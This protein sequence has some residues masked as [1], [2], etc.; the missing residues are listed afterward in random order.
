MKRKSIQLIVAGGIDTKTNPK[1]VKPGS[2]LQMDN[3]YQL[4]TG[5]WRARNGF[6]GIL[7]ADGT[8]GTGQAIFAGATGG[9]QAIGS[10]LVEAG[11]PPGTWN[12]P[13][14]AIARYS[15]SSSSWWPQQLGTNPAAYPLYTAAITEAKGQDSSTVMDAV[16]PD[17]ALGSATLGNVR[18]G[19]FALSNFTRNHV[20]ATSLDARPTVGMYQDN[21]GTLTRQCIK[22]VADLST[23]V[24]VVF[25]NGANTLSMV[26]YVNGAWTGSVVTL[27]TDLAANGF[28]DI[29]QIPGSSNFV[30]AYAVNG[31]GIKCGIF[32]RGT[33]GPGLSGTVFTA[34]GDATLCLGFLDDNLATGNMYLATAGTTS[35]VVLRTMSAVTLAVSATVA[36]DATSTAGV[37]NVTGHVLTGA[38]DLVV[39]WDKVNSGSPL[40]DY[41]MAAHV[42]GGTPTIGHFYGNYSLYSRT[43]LFPDGRY[44][45]LG[46]LTSTAQP[47]YVLLAT[48]TTMQQ[49]SGFVAAGPFTGCPMATV[50]TG[51]GGGRRLASSLASAVTVGST[52]TIPAARKRSIVVPGGS[53][54]QGR[55]MAYLTFSAMTGIN[56]AKELGGSVFLPGGTPIVDDGLWVMPGT[57]PLYPEIISATG[58]GG[59]GMTAS[60]SYNYRAVLKIRDSTGRVYRSAGS[61]PFTGTT[62]VGQGTIAVV[63]PNYSA[64]RGEGPL[65]SLELYRQGPA[66]SGANLYN[67]VLESALNG[68]GATLTLTDTMSDANAALGEVAYFTGNVLEHFQPPASSVLEVN[69]QRVG[70]INAEAPTEFWFSK[71]L[72]PGVGLGFNPQ[73]KI[74]I[75]GDGAGPL[76]AISAMDGRWILFKASAIYVVSGVGPDDTGAGTFNQPQAITRTVGTVNPASVIETPEGIL[77]QASTG[78]GNQGGIWLVGRDLSVTYV[79]APVEAYALAGNVVGAALCSILPTVRLVFA[80]GRMIE[81]DYFQKKWYVH[82]LRVD[83][84][85]VASTVVGCANTRQFGWCYMLANGEVLREVNGQATDNSGTNTAIIPVIS[86]PHLDMAGLNGYQRFCAL[87]LLIDV[88]GNHTFSVDAEYNYSGALT[89]T[90]ATKALTAAAGGQQ[91]EYLPPE[92]KAKCTSVRPVLTVQ[93]APA[94]ATFRLTGATLVY[95]IKSGTN[96]PATSRL[97]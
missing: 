25:Q 17:V 40:S 39:L 68:L 54:L 66:A 95:G 84:A 79:G 7:P 78:V 9:L 34:G 48:Y 1:L 14:P 37:N 11:T 57:F 4:R 70:L 62:G 86:F 19:T 96:I 59:G 13:W 18:I 50:L 20:V 46:C 94:G 43:V 92:G 3:L 65:A 74:S 21:F 44:Y 60:S 73:N 69:G 76:T 53:A 16:D 38:T 63:F 88:T 97:T 55:T 10:G 23:G 28:F 33:V 30:C 35:G 83:N 5:E 47:A 29:K 89:G 75:T 6:T 93:G 27:A 77:F 81:W 56:R 41:I 26:P 15:S 45:V 61:I 51:E 90:P 12:V 58:F 8:I 22:V 80:S 72:K 85:G 32:S 49:L 2:A 87:D 91:V 24:M 71:E 42:V 52:V 64:Y 82:L 36:V 31:G 67:K